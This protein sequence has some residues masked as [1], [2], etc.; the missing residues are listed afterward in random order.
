MPNGTTEWDAMID[1]NLSLLNYTRTSI[2]PDKYDLQSVAMHEINEVLGT[3]SQ[4]PGNTADIASMDL[5]RYDSSGNRSF[6]TTGDDAYFSIDGTTL[7]AR[8][9]QDRAGDFGDFWSLGG[10]TYQLQDAFAT[11]GVYADMNVETVMLDVV[12]YTLAPVPEPET[13]AMM[14]AGLALVGFAARRRNA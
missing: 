12:G 13:Y 5:F 1:L 11:P 10:H 14:L 9:N 2:D 8:F 6:T 3:T 4:L 7:L